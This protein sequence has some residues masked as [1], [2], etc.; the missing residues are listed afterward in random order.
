MLVPFWYLEIVLAFIYTAS[1][2]VHGKHY[3]QIQFARCIAMAKQGDT[4]VR[5]FC[6]KLA[7]QVSDS[8]IMKRYNYTIN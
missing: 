3:D 4:C 1:N 7:F 6:F 8:H 5:K 2:S